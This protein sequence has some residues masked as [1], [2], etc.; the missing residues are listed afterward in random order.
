MGTLVFG[1]TRYLKK[2]EICVDDSYDESNIN[3]R[4]SGLS[5]RL[6]ESPDGSS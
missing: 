6:V 3:H 4:D 5:D 2:K 1:Y